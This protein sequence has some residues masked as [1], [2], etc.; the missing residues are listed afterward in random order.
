MTSRSFLLFVLLLTACLLSSCAGG[1]DRRWRA[2]AGAPTAGGL[3]GRWDGIWRSETNGHDGRLRCIVRLT[4]HPDI[5][6]FD[7][8]GSFAGIFRFHYT[9]DCA[10]RRRGRNWAIKG[11]SDLG[12]KGG[13]FSHEGTVADGKFRAAYQSARDRGVFEMTRPVP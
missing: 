2:A 12:W 1:F 6:R 7:Y 5:C 9:V 13:V 3:T 4:E 8:G 10:V 11:E